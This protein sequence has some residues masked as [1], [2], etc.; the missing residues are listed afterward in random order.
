M[1]STLMCIMLVK[2]NHPIFILDRLTEKLTYKVAD[3]HTGENEWKYFVVH[4]NHQFF[5]PYVVFVCRS[6]NVKQCSCSLSKN[7]GNR[8][9]F[10]QTSYDT[11]PFCVNGSL[12]EFTFSL[13]ACRRQYLCSRGFKYN[14][15]TQRRGE[16]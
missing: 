14:K 9:P 5:F 6:I 11:L 12:I 2:L 8:V 4:A 7:K 3:R 13:A 1:A 16:K 10:T 15:L